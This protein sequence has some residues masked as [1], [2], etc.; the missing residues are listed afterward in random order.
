MKG[1]TL[2]ECHDHWHKTATARVAGFSGPNGAPNSI[3]NETC[4]T[5]VDENDHGLSDQP[6]SRVGVRAES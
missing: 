5:L 3:H 4:V 6:T 2:N 1:S